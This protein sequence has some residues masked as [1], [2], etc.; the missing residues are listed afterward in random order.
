MPKNSRKADS[1]SQVQVQT[2]GPEA[3]KLDKRFRP[4]VVFSLISFK[5]NSCL[6]GRQIIAGPQ[7]SKL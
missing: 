3:K 6:P 1:Q 4:E 7:L 2:G 5:V